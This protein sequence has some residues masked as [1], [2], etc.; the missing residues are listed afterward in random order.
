ML[1]KY[2]MSDYQHNS[3]VTKH[4]Q[5]QADESQSLVDLDA[6]GTAPLPGERAGVAPPEENSSGCKAGSG[7][8]GR[9]D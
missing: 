9:R 3:T 5:F 6:A 8:L 4:V 7:G 1:T 2:T